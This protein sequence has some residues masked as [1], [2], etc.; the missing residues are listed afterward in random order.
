MYR[1]HRAFIARILHRQGLESS[2]IDDAVQDVFLVVHRR[3]QDF[4]DRT[5]IRNW[6]YGIARRVASDYRRGTRRGSRPFVLVG[7]EAQE[8][9]AAGHIGDQ[10]EAAQ[11]VEHFLARLRVDQRRVFLQS[12]LE[13]MTAAEIAESENLNINT[14]YSR[15]RTIRRSLERLMVRDLARA[16]R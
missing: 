14:V 15:L 12:E 10:V 3:L 5:S 9:A 7:E 2:I 1:A 4:D 6:L 11:A 8:S 13:G 16:V